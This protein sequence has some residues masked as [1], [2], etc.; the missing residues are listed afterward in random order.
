MSILDL[1]KS[2]KAGEYK[3]FPEGTH[4]C[5][6]VEFTQP[7]SKKFKNA[8]VASL[9]IL[10]SDTVKVGEDYSLFWDLDNAD[11]A[12]ANALRV[13]KFVNALIRPDNDGESNAQ[14]AELLENQASQPAKGVQIVVKAVRNQ[15]KTTDGELVFGKG[16]EPVMRKT[17]DFI[18]TSV[19]QTAEEIAK[20]R[21]A[22]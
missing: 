6:L 2:A 19:D 15:K 22:L 14:F 11:F 7:N 10:E 16:G 3:Y 13:K 9:R 12:K 4:K 8:L 1:Y 21:S 17:L 18:F 20:L 5:V